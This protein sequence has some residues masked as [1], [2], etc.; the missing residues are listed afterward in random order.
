LFFFFFPENLRINLGFTA[1]TMKAM[2]INDLLSFDVMDPPS[3]HALLSALEPLYSL[4][5]LDK[6]GLLTK[7]G[8]KM[9]EFPLDPP[10]SKMLLVSRGEI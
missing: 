1:L 9:A 2:G 10:L 3:P 8:K 4:G 5:A 6:E 7:L